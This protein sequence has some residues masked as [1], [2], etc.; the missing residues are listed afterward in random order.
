MTSVSTPNILL[1][2]AMH[3]EAL[4][5]IRKLGLKDMGYLSPNYTFEHYSGHFNG[6]QLNL[7]VN[8]KCKVFKVDQIGTQ[9]STLTTHLGIETFNPSVVLNAGTA[10]GFRSDSAQVGDVYL[11]Y[12]TANYHDRRI[13]IPGFKEYGVGVHPTYSCLGMANDL[14]LRTGVVT[15]GNSLDYTEQDMATIK[16]YNGVVKDM[17][18]A[19]IA[20]VAQQ[21][22]IPFLAIKS[23][24]DIVDGEKPTEE[25]FLENLHQASES[26]S[27]QVVRVLQW[28]TEGG[29]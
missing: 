21:H 1:V 14:G 25:E 26:L 2:M 24:T 6:F 17:E 20:W 28:L 22:N 27:K 9:A 3:D 12:P 15:T 4:P 8:G 23:I 29:V 19:A 5:I 13:N 11:S 16:S 10:G 18:A 7:I